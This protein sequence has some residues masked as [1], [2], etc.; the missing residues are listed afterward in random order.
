MESASSSRR[1]GDE[2]VFSP[3]SNRSGGRG[4]GGARGVF[5]M[6]PDGGE[7]T[8]NTV[9][10]STDCDA[11]KVRCYFCTGSCEYQIYFPIPPPRILED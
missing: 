1:D 8:E 7:E 9:L 6:S 3:A 4:G 2:G 11:R 10:D 5:D